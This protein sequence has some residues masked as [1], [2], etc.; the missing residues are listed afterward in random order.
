MRLLERGC[1]DF[2]KLCAFLDLPA[3]VAKKN[4]QRLVKNLHQAA[5]ATASMKNAGSCVH[6]TK[7]SR[8]GIA[9]QN[10]RHNGRYMD[11]TRMQLRIWRADYDCLGDAQICGRG[12]V[13]PLLYFKHKEGY[14]LRNYF[15]NAICRIVGFVT[16]MA[17]VIWASI[18]HNVQSKDAE[19]CNQFCPEG[20]MVQVVAI[21]VCIW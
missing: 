18:C 6:T 15:G 4:Y 10:R 9:S 20:L 12:S 1:E 21:E 2:R 11:A 14:S 3:P 8:G 7:C 13:Y 17:R 5:K 19:K 16:A